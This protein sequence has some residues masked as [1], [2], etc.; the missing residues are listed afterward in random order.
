MLKSI[1]LAI[2]LPLMLAD[3]ARGGTWIRVN[4]LGYLPVSRKT[5]VLGTSDSS[6]TVTGFVLHD[7]LTHEAV[8]R[9][10]TVSPSGAYGPFRASFRLD[11]TQFTSD[12]AYYIRAGGAVSPSFRIGPHVYDGAADYVLRYMRQQRCGYNPFLDDSCHTQDGYVIYR[13]GFDSTFIDVVGGWHDASDYL[14]YVT[15]SATAV[16]SM[17]NAYRA[18]PGIFGDSYDAAGRA[19]ANGVPDILDEA[20][21]GIA[22]LLKMNPAPREMYNQIADDRDHQG[23]RLPT[24]DTVDY[25]RGRQRPV[26][27]VTGEPQGILDF[28]NRTTGVASTAAKFAST[29]ALGALVFARE[30]PDAAHEL[31][32]RAVEAFEFG[33]EHPGVCQTAP[34]RA[35]YFYEEDNW[36]DD[37]ELAAAA[38]YEL[39]GEAAYREKS[40]QYAALEAF[41]PWMGADRARHYQWY[42]FMNHGRAMR[43]RTGI[44][45]ALESLRRGIDTVYA[46]GRSNPFLFGVPFI[47]CSNNLVSAM[48][49]QCQLYGSLSGD[50]TYAAMEASLRDW[51][52]GCNP[53][54]TSM[55]V[56]FPS[57]DASPNDPHSAFSHVYGYP[58]DGGLVDGPVYG[59]IFKGL[60]GIHLTRDDVFSEFQSELAVYH[61]DWGDYS[62]N[63]PTMDGTAGLTLPFAL[64]EQ[65]GRRQRLLQPAR[66]D[67]G[68]IVRMDTTSTA[69]YLMFSG[70][71]F[72]DGGEVI[73][74]T[75]RDDSVR[76]SFFFTGD[77]YRN[78]S[79]APLIRSLL[80]DGHYLGPHS[81]RHLLYADWSQRDSLLVTREEFL[82]DLAANYAAMKPFGISKEY[83]PFFLPPYEWHN[84]E[85]ARWCDSV[86]VTLVN[87]TPGTFTNS[88]YTHPGMGAQYAGSDSIMA[89]LM[90]V[91]RSSRAGLK[92]ALLLLHIGTDPRRTDKLYARLGEL[93]RD[94]RSRGYTFGV[95]RARGERGAPLTPGGQ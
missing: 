42:P 27:Y 12:G 91:E 28:R 73:R 8:W 4:R 30:D 76:A 68:G 61:D 72:A 36:A 50:S 49:T 54:G 79:C 26:Y 9:S 75:L 95:L 86:G 66:S 19:G 60:I 10:T 63:E 52:L 2:L 71:E 33:E 78:P 82:A 64:L 16:V 83:A 1:G 5:A 81:D 57:R 15:T 34:C 3:A 43:A 93:I 11:F 39:T 32:E 31:R 24:E 35:P 55:I 84:R 22:W 87:L 53:W 69:V 51:L 59:S 18:A 40:T 46:R 45:S 29:F 94:L 90:R 7:V 88:D 41:T 38:L 47:W 25:G 77:F 65:E 23:F 89:R 92:G 37:M 20:G 48:L 62:T 21:W 44:P 70:H 80:A 67:Q 17:L 14:Q 56:G 58:I 6:L 13:Q 74:A 85:V